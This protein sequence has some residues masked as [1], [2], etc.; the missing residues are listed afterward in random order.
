[1]L[2]VSL[3]VRTAGPANQDFQRNDI[4]VCVLLDSWVATVL[5]VS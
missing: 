4:G 2:V 5:M 1:M 3:L